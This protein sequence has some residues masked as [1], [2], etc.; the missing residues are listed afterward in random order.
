MAFSSHSPA[1]HPR[2]AVGHG[3]GEGHG[4]RSRVVKGADLAGDNGGHE[5]IQAIKMIDLHI[6]TF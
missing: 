4:R 1:W 6:S 2:C 3:L 5:D